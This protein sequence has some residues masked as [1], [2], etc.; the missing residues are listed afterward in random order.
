MI[1]GIFANVQI[2]DVNCQRQ[3]EITGP[4]ASKLVQLMTPRPP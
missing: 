4:D 2:W 3:V 1:T